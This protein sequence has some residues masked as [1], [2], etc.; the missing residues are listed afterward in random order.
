L[1]SEILSVLADGIDD[2]VINDE[3]EDDPAPTGRNSKKPFHDA[4]EEVGIEYRTLYQKAS[5]EFICSSSMN[6]QFLLKEFHDHQMITS[7]RDASGT[8]V[9]AFLWKGRDGGL[10][11]MSWCCKGENSLMRK[12]DR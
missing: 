3:D 8:E 7:R 10:C 12:T 6:F 9:L 11:W 1:L 2:P 5:E 4:A